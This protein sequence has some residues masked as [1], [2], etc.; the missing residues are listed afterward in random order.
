MDSTDETFPKYVVQANETGAGFYIFVLSYS[1]CSFLL[2]FP[3]VHWSRG[4]E[5]AGTQDMDA[6]DLDA[7]LDKVLEREEGRD[8]AKSSRTVNKKGGD[9]TS[10]SQPS[11][12]AGRKRTEKPTKQASMNESN[13]GLGILLR[14]AAA[15]YPDR[16]PDCKS[17]TFNS[18]LP[19]TA[20][21]RAPSRLSNGRST[22]IASAA[23]TSRLKL[24]Q[25]SKRP[26]SGIFDVGGRRWK[27]R[28]PIGRADVIRNAIQSETGS[29]LSSKENHVPSGPKRA[30]RGMSDVASS[31]LE[32]EN[33]GV[34]PG[35]INRPGFNHQR[36]RMGGYSMASSRS[37]MSS[38]VDDISPNDAADADDPGRGNIFLHEDIQILQEQ[39]QKQPFQKG[40]TQTGWFSSIL[41]L[42]RP[43]DE[44]KRV[45]KTALPLSIGA[46]SE[47][48]FRLV[49]ASFISQYLG[50]QSMIAYLL[51]GLFVR[52]T[53]EEL[54]GAIIDALSSFLEPTLFSTESNGAYLSGQYIQVAMLLQ[55]VLGIPLLVLWALTMNPVINWLVQSPSVALIAEEY[56]RIAVVGYI[57]QSISRTFT[58][59][60]H[61]CGHEHFESVIDIVT[62]TLQMVAIACVVA[63][64]DAS[65]L[66]TVAYIQVLVCFSACVAKVGF[67]IF[68]GWEKPFRAGIFQN[69]SLVKVSY[70]INGV[71]KALPLFS[72]SGF[73]LSLYSF[74]EPSC[75]VLSTTRCIPAVA[76]DNT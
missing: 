63:L 35:F 66:K 57:F 27:H 23:T 60:F 48:I 2:I 13:N 29:I 73:S 64:V 72:N 21:S 15:E 41:E 24:S 53:S 14:V 59:V 43:T 74:I 33:Q 67:P 26:P 47:A 36:L 50:S 45:I 16:D 7:D 20:G 75:N 54:T 40:Q 70:Q 8:A 55:L 65:D 10:G 61:I 17:R 62:S 31:I 4:S 44:S 71:A 39:Q 3:L 38:I 1:L 52:L 6:T 69:F 37:V 76:W 9:S 32:E 34:H 46:T 22:A 58:A 49:T 68:K 18:T 12:V 19:P 56:T 42:A 5:K 51:V 30:P 25:S 11:S 28:R